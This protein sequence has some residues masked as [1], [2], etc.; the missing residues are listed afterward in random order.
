MTRAFEFSDVGGWLK[1]LGCILGYFYF[2]A[3]G[4]AGDDF[5]DRPNF[6]FILLDD[7]GW[8]DFGC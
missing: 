3:P 2:A 6:V 1:G 8:G 5:K 4:F 7:A